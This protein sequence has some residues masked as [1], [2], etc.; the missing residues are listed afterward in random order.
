[1]VYIRQLSVAFAI[2]LAIDIY[3]EVTQ[4]DTITY[5][6]K[7]LLMP[8]LWLLFL[9]NVHDNLSVE[10]RYLVIALIFSWFG[11]ILLMQHR[12]DFFLFGLVSFLI[13]HI[14]YI[15]SFVVGLQSE[16]HA[17]RR[18]LNLLN[19]FTTSIPF[20]AYVA[21]MIYILFPHLNANTEETKGLLMPVVIYAFVVVGMA[22]TSYLRD[23]TA[24]G[25]WIVFGGAVLFVLSDSFLAFNKFVTP[26]PVPGLPVMFTYGLG[27]Y[28]ITVGT[29]KAANKKTKSG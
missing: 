18:R 11:D 2:L 25:F 17:L 29:L 19:M 3:S 4:N 28:L 9:L 24:P 15:I 5:V 27:Q 13:A 8:V 16:G 22:Y 14:S 12:N 1:M 7:P 10:R 6:T 21:L 23:H 26:I 20:L